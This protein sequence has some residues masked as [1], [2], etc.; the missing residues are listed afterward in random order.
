VD[1]ART[2][3]ASYADARFTR[4]TRQNLNMSGR[5][6]WFRFSDTVGIG[7][8]VLVDGYWGFAAS[9]VWTS[10]K[11]V[12]L[13]R[14]ATSQARASARGPHRSVDLPPTPIVTGRWTTPIRIDPF[15]QV[16]L[17]EKLDFIEFWKLR[18]GQLNIGFQ[19]AGLACP[20]WFSREEHVLATSD[21]SLVT[22][23]LYQSGAK[24]ACVFQAAKGGTL[25]FSLNNLTPAGKGWE[26]L[27]DGHIPEQFELRL[28]EAMRKREMGLRKSLLVG[29]YTLVCDG[30]TMAAV[31]DQTLGAATQIDRALGYEA[32]AGG[33]SFLDEPLQMLGTFQVAS[34]LVN[35]TAN[36]S[37]P[38]DLATVKWDAE[39][40]VPQDF[41]LVKDGMLTDFQ[42]TREQA[43]WLAPYYQKT[44]RSIRSN[45]CAAAQDA[46]FIPM[47]HPPNLVLEPSTGTISLNDLIG[48]VKAGIFLEDGVVWQRDAQVRNGLLAG[49]M[50]E[51]NNGRLGRPVAGG[52]IMFNTKELW[53]HITAVGDRSTRGVLA[54][55]DLVGQGE[56]KKGQPEQL[57]TSHTVRAAA[58]TI[59]DQAFIDPSKKA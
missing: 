54:A 17:E 32:N 28:A 1:A 13:A 25:A 56:E 15:T 44:G 14:T 40:V 35:V 33:T 41:V 3:G 36:R 48:N 52:A 51:I 22:Q 50:R 9:P 7:I 30:A 55:G 11:A 6:G 24:I 34:P 4:V 42:T 59:T 47:Q 31:L 26:L 5:V 37:M 21:G 43:A 38:A 39:G 19:S 2:A 20:L 58:A 12:E 23:T 57:L 29:R 27:L 46:H 10:E 53:K 8:R 16:S 49:S 18:A 45:G